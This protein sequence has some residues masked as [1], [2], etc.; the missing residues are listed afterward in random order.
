MILSII[1]ADPHVVF[2]DENRIKMRKNAYFVIIYNKTGSATYEQYGRREKLS[3]GDI[4]L[5]DPKFPY[6]MSL[7]TKFEH[8]TFR[9]PRY[10]FKSLESA[11]HN[12]LGRK[13]CSTSVS[14]QII[15][16]FLSAFIERIEDMD[17]N[18]VHAFVETMMPMFI[19]SFIH[20]SGTKDHILSDHSAQI[21]S[22]AKIFIADNL[23]QFDLSLSMVANHIGIS[24]RH[25]TRL[26]QKEELTFNGW[27]RAMRLERCATALVNPAFDKKNISDIALIYGLNDISHFCRD[28]KRSFGYSPSQYRKRF[29]L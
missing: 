26:F 28:F 4:I 21:L 17:A 10:I 6:K 18:S 2:R 27:V 1:N 19:Q 8:I 14:G 3:A 23:G 11:S 24:T 12:L 25:L 13:I 20:E 22:R 5:Y 7:A 9:I 15:S 29:R 16:A